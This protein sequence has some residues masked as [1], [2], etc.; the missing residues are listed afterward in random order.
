MS[1]ARF[2]LS[3]KSSDALVGVHPDL[4]AV[5]R[6]AMDRQV[7]D[8]SVREGVRSLETQKLYVQRKVS[9]TLK[10]KHLIQ[11][12]GYGHAVD[13]YPYPID[14]ARVSKGDA[15]EISRF[16][17]LAGVMMAVAADLNIPLTWGGDWDRD[18]ETLDH[19][20]FDGPHFQLN[21]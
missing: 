11:A 13:L 8:F 18:G 12:D 14:M 3:S 10:S 7:M 2:K 1:Q 21:I 9:K 16:G 15:R 17:F 4:V 19:T 6:M 5:V 20:F